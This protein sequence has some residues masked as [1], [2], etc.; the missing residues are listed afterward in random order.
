MRVVQW[1]THGMSRRDSANHPAPIAKN[2]GNSNQNASQPSG[3][4]VRVD[5]TGAMRK[6]LESRV[7]QGRVPTTQA[8]ERRDFRTSL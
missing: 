4:A 7:I 1:V 8:K 2:T 6:V 3:K 5:I